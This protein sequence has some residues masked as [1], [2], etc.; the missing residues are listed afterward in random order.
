LFFGF[1]PCLFTSVTIGAGMEEDSSLS[2]AL[3]FS[4]KE[5]I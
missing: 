4:S 2:N 3:F 5:G 1:D